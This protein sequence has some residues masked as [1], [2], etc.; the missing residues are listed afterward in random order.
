MKFDI[1]LKKNDCKSNLIIL[2]NN[3]KNKF[4]SNSFLFVNDLRQIKK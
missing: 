2:I 1:K 3:E 4:N